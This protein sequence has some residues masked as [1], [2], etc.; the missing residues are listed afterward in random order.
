MARG[1][2]GQGI[3]IHSLTDAA[4]IPLANRATPAHG[5]ERAHVMPL[6]DAVCLRTGTRGRPRTRPKVIATDSG[7]DAKDLRLQLRTRGIRAQI[8]KRVWN[9]KKSQVPPDLVANL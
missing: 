9:T 1:G 6:L 8:P 7:D 3:L 2:Q 5:S 4:G